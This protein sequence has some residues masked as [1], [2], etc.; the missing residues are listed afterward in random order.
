MLISSYI[1]ISLTIIVSIIGL[2]VAYNNFKKPPMFKFKDPIV[3][4]IVNKDGT[5][6]NDIPYDSEVTILYNAKNNQFEII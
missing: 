6:V 2:W 3:L 1:I 5:N 4:D